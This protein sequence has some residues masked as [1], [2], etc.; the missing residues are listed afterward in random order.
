[1][2]NDNVYKKVEKLAMK[3]LNAERGG[4]AGLINYEALENKNVLTTVIFSILSRY[5]VD[6]NN[7]EIIDAFLDDSFNQIY[8]D[9]GEFSYR[10][11]LEKVLS[12][13]EGLLEKLN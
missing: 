10:H 6:R 7:Q 1:M 5:Y 3:E 8:K 4:L 2:G 9:F 12:D 11:V 13:L